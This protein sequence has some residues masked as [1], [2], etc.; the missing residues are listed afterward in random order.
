MKKQHDSVVGK[1]HQQQEHFQMLNE[2]ASG[3][4]GRSPLQTPLTVYVQVVNF[5]NEVKALRAAH[6]CTPT[7]KLGKLDHDIEALENGGRNI[8]GDLDRLRELLTIV[9]AAAKA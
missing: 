8:N 5:D 9:E 1:Y 4:P 3:L 6:A 2:R 7:Q